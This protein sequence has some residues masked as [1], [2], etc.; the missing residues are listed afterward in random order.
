MERSRRNRGINLKN[1][2]AEKQEATLINQFKS[3]LYTITEFRKSNIG[4]SAT[5]L[6]VART[7]RGLLHY[8]FML[9]VF[10]LINIEA[11]KSLSEEKFLMYEDMSTSFFSIV[12]IAT[13][14]IGFIRFNTTLKEFP[15]KAR[16]QVYKGLKAVLFF[17]LWNLSFSIKELNI[18][19]LAIGCVG[20]LIFNLFLLPEIEKSYLFN[21]GFN[22][23]MSEKELDFLQQKIKNFSIPNPDAMIQSSKTYLDGELVEI[24]L[25]FRIK[26]TVLPEMNVQYRGSWTIKKEY[27]E[28]NN[29]LLLENKIVKLKLKSE[30]LIQNIVRFL[31]NI[32]NKD[33]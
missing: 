27:Q 22:K 4:K 1:K 14:L 3:H 12:S 30:L 19:N 18:Q 6:E 25:K 28:I 11:V 16:N 33:R 10:I 20:L 23:F 24:S 32:I 29:R 7:S 8:V 5:V 13:L 17:T 15:Y 21:L 26:H 9:N 2:E 31:R